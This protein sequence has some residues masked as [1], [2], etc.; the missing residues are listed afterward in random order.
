MDE[1]IF[2]V[3]DGGYLG[4]NI[5]ATY[6][7]GHFSITVENPWAGDTETGFGYSCQI[8]MNVEEAR[9][10]RDWLTARLDEMQPLSP[11]TEEQ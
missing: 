1:P 11:T 8:G 6:R 7:D 9:A 5:E 2:T 10:F 3:D 4:N